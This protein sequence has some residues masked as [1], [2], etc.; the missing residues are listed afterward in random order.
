MPW[1]WIKAVNEIIV[2]EPWE[3][4]NGQQLPIQLLPWL[5]LSD[6]MSVI[7]DAQALRSLGITHVLS[8][9]AMPPHGLNFIRDRLRQAGIKHHH[10]DGLD[11]MR[12]D[13]IGNHWDECWQILQDVRKSGGKIVVHC[14]AG[15]NRSG[16]IAC[17]AV[18]LSERRPVLDTVKSTKNKRGMLLTNLSFQ[19]Q[20]CQLAARE[21]LLGP[22]PDGYTD[23]PIESSFQDCFFKD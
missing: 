11:E 1:A 17:A 16:V 2:S 8:T 13:M 21:G 19:R 20:L 18:M 14:F 23:D 12:Y 10:V 9:N 15:T 7:K 6:Q 4:P 3:P 22:K 5:W